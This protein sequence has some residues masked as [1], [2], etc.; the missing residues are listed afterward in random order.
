MRPPRPSKFGEP[1][2]ARRRS[3]IAAAVV[4]AGSLLP[5]V[6]VVA[7]VPFLP[8]LGLLFLVAWRQRSPDVLPVW[9]GAPLGLW[10]DLLSGHPLGSAMSLWT[11]VMLSIDL[12]DH[13]LVWRDF[14]QE[15]LVAG[16]A[17]AGFLIGAR[18]AGTPLRAHVDTVLLFQI[19]ISVALYPLAA[20]FCAW[21]D[22][23]GQQ[24][25]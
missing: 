13:R 18:L 3:L 6:P 8:P 19:A 14:W 4:M 5:I 22:E 21:V 12:I 11:L 20:A 9:A 10:D 2:S 16:G 1:V 25:R 15:W 23:R 7:V 24:R 17:V